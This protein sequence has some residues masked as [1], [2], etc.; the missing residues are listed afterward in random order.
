LQTR[1]H[2][3]CGRFAHPHNAATALT[4]IKKPSCTRRSMISSVLGG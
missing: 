4:S 3:A 2:A 1:G